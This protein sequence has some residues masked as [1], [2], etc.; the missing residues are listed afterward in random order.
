ME[1]SKGN[2][3]E[4]HCNDT[5]HLVIWFTQ[6]IQQQI[7]FQTNIVEISRKFYLYLV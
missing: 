4:Q 7:G 2:N 1:R 5:N 3:K 6:H